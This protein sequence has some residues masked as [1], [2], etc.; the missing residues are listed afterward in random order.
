M[1]IMG[2]RGDGAPVIVG[3]GQPYFVT[4]SVMKL[5][6]YLAVSLEIEGIVNLV[7][8]TVICIGKIRVELNG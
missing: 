1:I 7:V 5:C 3:H 2:E 8:K 6:R 4:R